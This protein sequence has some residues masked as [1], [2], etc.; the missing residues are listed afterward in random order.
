MVEKNIN[1]KIRTCLNILIMGFFF[2]C[3][4]YFITGKVMRQ[5]HPM[6]TFLF[7]TTDIFG[8]FIGMFDFNRDFDPFHMNFRGFRA[9]YPPGAYLIMLP[10]T[11]FLGLSG[12]WF[13][14]FAYIFSVIKL[15]TSYLRLELG[16]L[17]LPLLSV[18]IIF[19][20][21]NYPSLF[22][23]ERLNTENLLFILITI[24]ILTLNTKFRKL[25]YVALVAAVSAKIYPILFLFAEDKKTLFKKGIYIGLGALLLNGLA[26][27]VFQ[28]PINEAIEAYNAGNTIIFNAFIKST[29]GIS[30]GSSFCGFIKTIFGLF[31][32]GILDEETSVT[33]FKI[34]PLIVAPA[35]F[36]TVYLYYKKDFLIWQRLFFSATFIVIWPSISF[37]YKLIHFFP[38]F[39][40][41]LVSPACKFE[42]NISILFSFLFLPLGIIKFFDAVTSASILHPLIIIVIWVLIVMGSFKTQLRSR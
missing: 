1:S 27:L 33:I 36:F 28:T 14:V 10:F 13:Y 37:D 12:L 25:G 34:A 35:F 11:N 5:G 19:A 20:L 23:L 4:F 24:Y 9:T 3:L 17:P 32:D 21:M 26:L 39:A 30:Y 15:F 42:K 41:F 29:E 38:A 2:S 18:A 7:T 22:A 16:A 8:D 31:S 6:D 40:A